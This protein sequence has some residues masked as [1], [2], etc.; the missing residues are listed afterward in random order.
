[1]APKSKYLFIAS[2]DVDSSKE[3]L[4]ND[5]YNTEHC[6]ELSKVSG[7]GNITR[8]EAQAFQVLMEAN[9]DSGTRWPATFPRHV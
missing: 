5:V 4:F 1:M 6:P 9:P 7:V 8:F 3:S 2:M